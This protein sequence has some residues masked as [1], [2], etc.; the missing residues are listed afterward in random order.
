M[1]P[2]RSLGG[3]PDE[4]IHRSPL[5]TVLLEWEEL[6][7]SPFSEYRQIVS[8]TLKSFGRSCALF[9][10]QLGERVNLGDCPW[11]FSPVN[12]HARAVI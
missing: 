10:G 5:E 4:G 8:G 2:S 9:T 6:R 11:V 1:P 3:S 7:P 12:I